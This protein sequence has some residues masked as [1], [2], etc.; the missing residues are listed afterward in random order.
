[1]EGSTNIQRPCFSGPNYSGHHLPYGKKR[2]PSLSFMLSIFFLPESQ[3]QMASLESKQNQWV[4]PA[5]Q[6]PAHP[7]P[8]VPMFPWLAQPVLDFILSPWPHR[9]GHKAKQ[10]HGHPASVCSGSLTYCPRG[11]CICYDCYFYFHGSKEPGMEVPAGDPEDAN[12][13]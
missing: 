10:S 4:T 9:M 11:T 12:I 1:M 8:V 3:A 6:L 7:L 2:V 5:L 13:F